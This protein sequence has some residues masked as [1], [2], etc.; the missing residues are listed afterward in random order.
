MTDRPNSLAIADIMDLVT[1][2]GGDVQK[3]IEKA[4]DWEHTRK[5]EAG[6]WLLATG[7]AA[8]IGV[9]TLGAKEPPVEPMFLFILAG[10]G[11]AAIV[12]GFVALWRAGT[13][14]ARLARVTAL[15]YRLEEIKPFLRLLRDKQQ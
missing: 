7:T 8:F 6:K 5:L 10:G 14:P 9:V 3:I 15:A 11:A 2:E 13:M 4:Y 12:S 1:N